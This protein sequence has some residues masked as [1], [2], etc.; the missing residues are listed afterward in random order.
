VLYVVVTP[1]STEMMAKEKA[2]LET[3]LHMYVCA[4]YIRKKPK[5]IDRR[6]E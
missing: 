2:K 3:T 5:R 1:V 6:T 4:E